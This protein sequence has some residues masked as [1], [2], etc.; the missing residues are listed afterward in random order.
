MPDG[1][2]AGRTILVIEDEYVVA[3]DLKAELAS[4]GATI[5][6]P[7]ASLAKAMDLIE[8]TSTIDAAILDINLGG[9]M[10]FEAADLLRKRAVPFILSTGYDQSL[11]PTR[12]DDVLRYE[13]PVSSEM[14]CG[15]LASILT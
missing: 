4:A 12:F 2:L 8:A 6:G 1:A 13:K 10:A 5:I 15:R 11:I 7:V 14:L 3:M 9:Q